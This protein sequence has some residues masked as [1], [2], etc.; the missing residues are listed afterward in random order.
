MV[1]AFFLIFKNL[2]SQFKLSI[3]YLTYE[4]QEELWKIEC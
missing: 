2:T 3:I 4:E 1:S